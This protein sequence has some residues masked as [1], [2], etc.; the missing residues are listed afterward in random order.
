[1]QKKKKVQTI[2]AKLS[3]FSQNELSLVT[4]KQ[5]KKQHQQHPLLPQ[6]IIAILT[7]SG[8]H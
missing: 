2:S 5:S 3:K 7:Y 4:R 6:R 8:I 1:M